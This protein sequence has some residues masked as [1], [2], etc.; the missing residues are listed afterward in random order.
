MVNY[1]NKGA[2]NHCKTAIEIHETV[3]YAWNDTIQERDL[4][5]ECKKYRK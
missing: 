2:C 3:F 4:H 5:E 1:T